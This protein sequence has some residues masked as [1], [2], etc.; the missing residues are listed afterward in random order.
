MQGGDAVELELLD[1]EDDEE[2]EPGK[3]CVCLSI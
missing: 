3:F 2:E 1:N